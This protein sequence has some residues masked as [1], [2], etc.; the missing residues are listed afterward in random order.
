MIAATGQWRQCDRVR[1]GWLINV[2]R[3]PSHSSLLDDTRPTARSEDI[4]L[5]QTS[6]VEEGW[7]PREE[8]GKPKFEIALKRPLTSSGI[9][10]A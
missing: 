1:P 8:I 5:G 10:S 3:A 6:E 2:L 9:A 7:N 4:E